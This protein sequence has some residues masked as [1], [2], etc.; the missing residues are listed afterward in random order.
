M[1]KEQLI[2]KINNVANHIVE[3]YIYYIGETGMRNVSGDIIKTLDEKAN[4]ELLNV[5]IHLNKHYPLV[6]ISEETGVTFFS[7]NPKYFIFVD[8]IDGSN[9]IR[10]HYTPS[11]NLSISIGVGFIKDL[12][13]YKDMRAFQFTITRDIF[14]GHIYLST[15]NSFSQFIDQNG[16]AIKIRVTSKPIHPYIIGID[17]DLQNRLNDSLI[18]LIQERIIQRRLGSSILD[19]CQVACGQYDGYISSQG[20]LKITDIAQSH[21]LVVSSAGFFESVCYKDG[22]QNEE[23]TKSYMYDVLSDESL[24]KR[25][26]FTVIAG[27]HSKIYEVLKPIV[28][29]LILI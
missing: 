26:K 29:L 21:H 18:D 9:N 14:K 6:V 8:P 22:I 11:P 23:L 12:E 10:S 5:F 13:T 17:L 4:N 19:L 7:A 15:T 1:L 20:R 28:R 16:K 2:E 27:C 25:L 24:L 3:F